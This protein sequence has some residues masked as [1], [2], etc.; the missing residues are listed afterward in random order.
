[1]T[2]NTN[3]TNGTEEE[4]PPPREGEINQIPDVDPG[5][6][7]EVKTTFRSDPDRVLTVETVDPD[8]DDILGIQPRALG[9]S[10]LSESCIASGYGTRYQLTVVDS[11]IASW[12]RVLLVWPSSDGVPV[13]SIEI[14]EENDDQ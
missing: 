1:M 4:I 8:E 12:R 14:V 3:D 5:D 2:D 7:I 10:R 13:E 6:R 9:Y 11:L